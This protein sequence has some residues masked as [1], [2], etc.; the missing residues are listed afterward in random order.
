MTFGKFSVELAITFIALDS[1]SS[2]L[3][4]HSLRPSSPDC[5]HEVLPPPARRS[6]MHHQQDR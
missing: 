3:G 4:D 5:V 1:G 2:A 6:R